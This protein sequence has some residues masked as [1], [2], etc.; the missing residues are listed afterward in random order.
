MRIA[1]ASVGGLSEDAE[2]LVHA[3]RVH[4]LG[5]YTCMPAALLPDGSFV[6]P[7]RGQARTCRQL[8][9]LVGPHDF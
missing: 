3:A 5:T 8:E 4:V 1:M 7:E 6:L 2:A 9:G